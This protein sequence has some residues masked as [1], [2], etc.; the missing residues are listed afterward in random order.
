MLKRYIPWK[1]LIKRAARAYGVIDPLTFLAR[2][3]QFSQPSE[4]Q[5]PIELVRAG[6]AFHTRGLINTKAIQHNLDWIWPYWVVKQFNPNDTSFIPRAFSFSHVN[7]THRN[8]TAVGH[9]EIPLYPIVDPRGLV[10]PL[11]D[12]WSLDLWLLGEDTNIVVPSKLENIEQ[13]WILSPNL[14]VR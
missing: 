2:I 10:T 6:I 7:L 14:E 12:G 4:V 3:R 8:W 11:F 5:E 1:F 13:E 9:P